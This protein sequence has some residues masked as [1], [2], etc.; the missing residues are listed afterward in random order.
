MGVE[1][2]A[3]SFF[4]AA[5][6]LTFG[7]ASVAVLAASNTWQRLTGRSPALAGFVASVMLAFG[8][9][10]SLQQLSGFYDCVIAF[11]NAC[12]LFSTASG[13]QE[14]AVVPKPPKGASGEKQVEG[15]GKQHGANVGPPRKWRSSWFR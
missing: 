5:S 1:E 14:G 12:L 15:L 6:L 10:A 4:T 2:A 13:M 8:G 7:G 3:K 11:F 9:A